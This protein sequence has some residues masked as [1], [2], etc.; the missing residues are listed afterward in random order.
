[1]A[2]ETRKKGLGRGLSALMGEVREA[3]N[4]AT[5]AT[6]GEKPRAL[7]ELPI[8]QIQANPGQPRKRFTAEALEDLVASIKTHGILQPILVR[9]IAGDRYEIIAGERR[10]RAAQSAQLHQVPVVIKEFTDQEVMEVALVEN[11]QRADL[12]PIEEAAGYQRLI[13]DFGHTQD[14][15]ARIIGKSRSHIANT[16][17]LLA[18]P[19]PVKTL[20][21]QGSLSAGHAR[22][23]IGLPDAAALAKKAVDEGLSVRQIE[24]LAKKAKS[25]ATGTGGA[26]GG[27]PAKDMDTMELEGNLAAA[28]GL[29]VLIAHKGDAGGSLTIRYKTLDELDQICSKLSRVE[30]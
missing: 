10:W 18:L 17:R 23:L 5:P 21:E 25:P 29:P 9:K 13:E 11:I 20:V 2:E 27:A 8:E 22:A 19:A 16:L 1:M 4:T 26:G 28:I 6:P 14:V 3:V 7:R 30:D 15:I 12:T 24:D